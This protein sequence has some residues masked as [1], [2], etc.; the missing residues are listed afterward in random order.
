MFP[1]KLNNTLQKVPNN[2]FVIPENRMHRTVRNLNKNPA[3]H[4]HIFVDA[5]MADM[6]AVA[7]VRATNSRNSRQQAPF[8][9]GRC[10]VAPIK[11]TSMAKMQLKAA[12]I[13]I[14]PSMTDPMRNDT[15]I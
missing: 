9:I 10:Q 3:C 8:L 7:H 1:L 13:L 11:Q 5:S 4:F 15:D 2:Y 14:A 6:A 12:D